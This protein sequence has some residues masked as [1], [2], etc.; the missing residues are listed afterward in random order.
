MVLADDAPEGEDIDVSSE[1]RDTLGPW[2]GEVLLLSY[3]GL[4]GSLGGFDG[5]SS[6]LVKEDVE[7]REGGEG[8]AWG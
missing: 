2:S 6:A 3:E 5:V 7:G 1:K 4:M 8:G